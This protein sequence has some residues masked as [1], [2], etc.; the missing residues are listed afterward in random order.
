MSILQEPAQ[1]LASG[2]DAAAIAD[3]RAAFDA[4]R[5]AFAA[6]R[7]PSLEVRRERVGRIAPMMLANR[8]RISAALAEDFGS[9]PVGAAD[10]IETLAVVGRVQYVLENLEAWAAPQARP[11]GRR[12]VRRPLTPTSRCSQ[13]AWSAT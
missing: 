1:A 4:Q 8:E 13:R 7:R 10:L 3:L 2:D 5:K 9:H 12:P 6:D 11:D